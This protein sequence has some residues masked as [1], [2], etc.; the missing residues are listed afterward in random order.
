MTIPLGGP[1]PGMP[2]ALD[3]VVGL[4]AND[5]VMVIAPH[6]DDESLA[7]AGLLQASARAAARVRVVF[8]TDG[9]N[10][11]WAQLVAEG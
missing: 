5:R 7:C 1:S 11:P 2:G 10:N 9:D 6:P 8:L 4:G 3:G